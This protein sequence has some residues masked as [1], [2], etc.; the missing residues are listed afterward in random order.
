MASIA[1]KQ[2]KAWKAWL[3]ENGSRLYMYARQRCACREDAEDMM[4]DALV[5]LWHYQEERG[6]VPPD[7]PLAYSVLRFV[8]LDH[9][10]KQ[11][12]KQKKEK[13]ILYLHDAEDYWLD[14]SVEDD[15]EA[16]ILRQAV[17]A[18]GEKLREV[19]TLKIWGGLT[20][21]EIAES[22]AISPNTA[23]SRY[24][25]ALEQLERKLQTFNQERQD[26]YGSFE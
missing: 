24:R 8:A 18:L 3:K 12:R 6:N 20:F 17:N 11:G 23:A 22:M 13:A 1:Q 25:Y 4:Q 26:R 21:Q 9:G 16:E 10:K 14:S 15:D 5:R 7:L 2:S 19:V